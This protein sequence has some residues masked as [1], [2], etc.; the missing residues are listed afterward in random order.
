MP[1][2]DGIEATRRIVADDLGEGAHP[3]HLRPRRL[4]LRRACGAGASGFLL[5][6]ADAEHLV[7]AV[8]A[9]AGGHALL[10]PEVTRRV[11]AQMTGPPGTGRPERQQRVAGVRDRRRRSTDADPARARGARARRP[12]AC[13]TPRSPHASSRRGHGQD[14]R[15]QRL[16]QARTCAT[17]CRPS[18]SPTRPGS[19][20]RRTARIPR[21]LIRGAGAPRR[22]GALSDHGDRVTSHVR[23]PDIEVR[24]LSRTFGEIR[25]VDDVSFDRA[26]RAAD[27]L[28]RRQRCGQDHDD[29]HASWACSS[30]TRRRG[31]LGRPPDHPADRR[32][33]RLHARGARP[34]P[35]AA[36]RSTS[37]ST[38]AGSAGIGAARGPRA[39]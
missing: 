9:V 28:R 33:L 19:S 16:R 14:P 12:R 36:G 27:R 25:A 15:V 13:R 5:K 39:R 30:P 34:L 8:R 31:A 17:G 1:V 20:S 29:A 22:S 38:S 10:A 4:R 26:G 37:S 18:S 11:I 32:A 23:R 2:M 3:H 7:E 35:Q 6:N 21:G 24:R